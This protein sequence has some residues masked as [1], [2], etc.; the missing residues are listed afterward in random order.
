VQH[1]RWK[2]SGKKVQLT[3]P[4][5]GARDS[6]K[7]TVMVSGTRQ[8]TVSPAV[9]VSIAHL[10]A[11][12]KAARLSTRLCQRWLQERRIQRAIRELEQLD[13]HT[14]ED[15]GLQR[16]TIESHVRTASRK[17]R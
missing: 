6:R 13:D 2:I 8:L 11:V 10:S 16:G 15:I 4:T 12:A 17:S 1:Y 3:Q 5:R 7:E 14:L 9:S